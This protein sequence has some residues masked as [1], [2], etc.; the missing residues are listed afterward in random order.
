MN[1]SDSRRNKKNTIEKA[2]EI[3]VQ[4]GLEEDEFRLVLE[5]DAEDDCADYV[6]PDLNCK[7]F[8]LIRGQLNF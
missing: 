4:H 6:F 5:C 2:H 3:L 8:R 7:A 1:Y